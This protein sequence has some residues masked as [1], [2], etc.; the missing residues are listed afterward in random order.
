MTCH[1]HSQH[2]L[3]MGSMSAPAEVFWGCSAVCFSTMTKRRPTPSVSCPVGRIYVLGAG[4]NVFKVGMTRGT[5]KQRIAGLSTGAVSQLKALC[6]I[7]VPIERLSD[8]EQY[9]HASLARS[10]IREAG[11][12]EFFRGATSEDDFVKTVEGLVAAYTSH[13]DRISDV[14]ERDFSKATAPYS[15]GAPVLCSDAEH[16]TLVGPDI[17]QLFD[18]RRD[19]RAEIKV[20]ELKQN[21]LERELLETFKDREV[22]SST[23]QSPLLRWRISTSRRVD[24]SALRGAHAAIV[25]D[26]TRS[27]STAS[28]RFT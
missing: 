24:L 4:N 28:P 25:E 1:S 16:L 6:E 20:L 13:C 22:S 23:D 15:L 19:L 12:S 2:D 21:A 3:L 18:E 10:R 7:I 5:L 26:F 8:C 11:G 9:V 14:L 17:V 27:V